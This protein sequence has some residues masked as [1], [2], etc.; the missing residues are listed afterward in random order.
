M[1]KY[2]KTYKAGDKDSVK[3]F[4]QALKDG[5]DITIECGDG[6][7]ALKSGA[8]LKMPKNSQKVLVWDGKQWRNI[9]K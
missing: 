9:G 6:D 8:L 5:T 1:K 2:K 3:A 4:N 7:I